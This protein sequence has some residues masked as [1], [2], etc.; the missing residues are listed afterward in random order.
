MLASYADRRERCLNELD[1]RRVAS[2]NS[3]TA[4]VVGVIL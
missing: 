4:V 3:F 1:F 2:I